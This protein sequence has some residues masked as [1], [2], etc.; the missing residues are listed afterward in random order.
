M[1]T[2]IF[3]VAIT[4]MSA[5]QLGLL[6]AEHNITNANTP[7][8]S[9]QRI[10]QTSA[11]ALPTGSGFIGQGVKVQTIARVY[12]GFLQNQ[13]HSAQ[14]KNSELNTYATQIKQIDNILADV[15]AGVSPALQDFFTGLQS[16]AANPSSIAARQSF[17]SA[18]QALATRFHTMESRFSEMYDSVNGQIENSVA[19]INSYG[20]QVAKLN[21]QIVVAQ[22][23]TGQPPNDLLDAR[24][25]LI[26]EL[27]KEVEVRVSGESDGSLSLFIGSGQPLVVG[28]AASRFDVRPASSDPERMVVGRVSG[29]SAYLELPESAFVGGN[30]TGYLR[31]RSETLDKAADA[32]GQI[33]GSIA[34]AFNAQQGLG[35]DLFGRVTGEAG[36]AEKLFLFD[37]VNV[38]KIISNSH[39]TGAGSIVA[40]SAAVMTPPGQVDGFLPPTMLN[41]NF[42]TELQGSSYEVSFGAGDTWSVKRLTDGTEVASGTGATYS[43][44]FDGISIDIE[45]TGAEGDKFVVQPVRELANSLRVNPLVASDPRLV[46][47]AA[48]V[49]GDIG[50]N[51]VTGLPNGGN[52]AVTSVSVGP[53]YVQ[54][55]AGSPVTLTYDATTQEFSG[56]P[57][58]P[59]PRPYDPSG[60]DFTFDGITISIAGV[61]ADQDTFTVSNNEGGVAD[62]SNAVLMGKLQTQNTMLGD[63]TGG[64]ASFQGVYAQLVSSVGN[65]TRELLVTADAQKVLLQQAQ[66]ARESISGVNTDEEAAN[67]L[68]YQ[69]AY[70]ASARMLQVGTVLFDTVLSIGR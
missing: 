68:R 31:F 10:G 44:A 16:M 28:Q 23:S 12:N 14:T 50:L 67:L 21:A 57:S 65:K 22:A 4:G 29:P 41:G 52:G 54:P 2:G 70:Q 30:L 66:S 34:S 45:V 69:Y 5:A 53:G 27:N 61:P 25:Q 39:N 58:G 1:S 38:P 43:V 3:S 59:N 64:K 7:G 9:R 17:V 55:A 48:P 63:A 8:Y 62:S 35:Q 26:A 46:A 40:T 20:E 6:T 13:I 32:L 33:A 15:T 60:T 36:F 19:L 11:T 51:A 49:R 24:E 56:F 47:V 42:V 18:G 37:A